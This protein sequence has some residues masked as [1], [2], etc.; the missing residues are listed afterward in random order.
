MEKYFETG[1]FCVTSGIKDR[2]D[3]KLEYILFYLI[4]KLKIEKDYLQV[5]ELE[6]EKNLIKIKHRQEVP[7]Y[8]KE[9]ILKHK[10]KNPF[11]KIFIIDS[12][13]SIVMMLSSEY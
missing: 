10:L 5:F 12:G 2:I 7:F 11:E 13:G 8:E 1:D 6:R 3:P 4:L 9:Y